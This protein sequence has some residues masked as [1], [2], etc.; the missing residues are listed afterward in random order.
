MSTVT[1]A[2][3]AGAPRGMFAVLRSAPVRRF[4]ATPILDWAIPPTLAVMIFVAFVWIV[5]V[6]K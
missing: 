3:T 5:F 2:V 6:P 4:I 1:D